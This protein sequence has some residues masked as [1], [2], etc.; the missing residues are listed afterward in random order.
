MRR[1]TSYSAWSPRQAE[2]VKTCSNSRAR[3]VMH[4]IY[5]G[6]VPHREGPA[7]LELR[8]LQR[9][10]HDRLLGQILRGELPP[11]T[12]LSPPEIASAFGVS[13]TPVRDAVNLL[14][15]E[16]LVLV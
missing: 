11:G 13:V 16:G 10:V 12:R 1:H 4:Q 8:S 5:N 2:H 15:A 9:Q 7:A 6:G 3:I 14:A